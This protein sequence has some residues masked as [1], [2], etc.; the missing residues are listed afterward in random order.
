MYT[1]LVLEMSPTLAELYDRVFDHYNQNEVSL[2]HA[3]IRAFVQ[4]H[5]SQE[6]ETREQIEERM[7]FYMEKEGDENAPI[8]TRREI[9]L[10]R[11]TMDWIRF[12]Q[13]NLKKSGI[14][15]DAETIFMTGIILL[16][17]MLEVMRRTPSATLS[18]HPIEMPLS[19]II[20]VRPQLY[21]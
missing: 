1:I 15:H 18:I 13:G 10:D 6:N 14:D 7:G 19:Q 11:A 4:F 5:E 21:N 20:A 16:S 3:S 8:T 9:F 12:S 17:I 2:A